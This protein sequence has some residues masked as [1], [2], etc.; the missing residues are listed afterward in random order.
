[1]DDKLIRDDV[2]DELDFEPSIDATN[3]GVAVDDGVVTL[4]GHV[5]SYAEKTAAECAAR[6]VRGVRAIAQEI[7][8]RYPSEKTT[9]DEEIAKRVLTVLNWDAM[10]PQDAVK[11]TVQ[12]AWV[13]LS[14]ELDWQYQKKA[15]EDA[16]RK[17][18]GVTGVTTAS[19]SSRKQSMYPTSR[20][21]SRT[22]WP[23]MRKSRLRRFGSMFEMATRFHLRGRSIVGRSAR[24]SR[25]QPGP[26]PAFNRSTIV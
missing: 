15:A 26:L 13:T 2:L 11:V 4:T 9:A 6:R 18:S 10:I 8:V 7:E 3:I 1:M 19:R 17:L 21:R 5:S 16:V 23:D 24:P 14:G 12:K 22:R 25:M 20:R